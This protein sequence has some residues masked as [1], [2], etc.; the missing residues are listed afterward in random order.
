MLGRVA[1]AWARFLPGDAAGWAATGLD[2]LFPPQCPIC[3]REPAGLAAGGRDAAPGVGPVCAACA[4]ELAADVGRCGRCGAAR[5]TAGGCRVCRRLRP[6][7][8]RTFVLGGYAGPLRDA[9]LRAKRPAGVRVV[10]ALA[11]LLVHRHG[12]SLRAAGAGC[13]VP[14][15]MHWWRRSLRGTS[16]ADDLAG[17]VAALIG[18]PVSR[19]LVRRRATRMQNELPVEERPRNVDGAFHVRRRLHGARVIL[20][21]DVMTTGATL[22]ACCRALAAAGAG[23]VDVAV[24]AR[25]DSLGSVDDD[26]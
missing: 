5:G 22:A 16:A 25:A 1:M 21:D 4:R 20:V 2:L 7:W 19:V 18:L 13:V 6:A 3:R 24:V 15:P 14:V 11:A 10:A 12:A 9:V 17:G 23:G 26:A 8:D